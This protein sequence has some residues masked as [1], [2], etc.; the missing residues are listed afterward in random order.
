MAKGTQQQERYDMMNA[1]NM[2]E[3][4]QNF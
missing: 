2:A 3:A 1:A 4:A